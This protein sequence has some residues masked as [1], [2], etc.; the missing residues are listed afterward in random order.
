MTPQ[1]LAEHL[2]ELDDNHTAASFLLRSE[3]DKGGFEVG[4]L[5][6]LAYDLLFNGNHRGMVSN[7]TY[8][9]LRNELTAWRAE[10]IFSEKL[11]LLYRKLERM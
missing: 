8:E 3:G 4:A 11:S 10:N 1:E 5:S 6:S 7:A 9:A 2:D